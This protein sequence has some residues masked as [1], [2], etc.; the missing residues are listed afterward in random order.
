MN[1]ICILA[2]ALMANEPAA[3]GT[4]SVLKKEPAPVV[5][6]TADTELRGVR[7]SQLQV[8]RLNR[9]A[10]RQEARD[11]RNCRCDC[12]EPKVL[13]SKPAKCDCR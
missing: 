4:V 12:T 8:R 3:D 11:E 5:A 2:V 9:I 1:L 6:T 13:L 7:L 10:D